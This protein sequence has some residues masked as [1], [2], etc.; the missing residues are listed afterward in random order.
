MVSIPELHISENT[1]V[2]IVGNNGAGKTTL[3]RLIL[4]LLKPNEGNVE[5][6]GI[7]PQVSEEWKLIT[8]AY[9]DAG[10]LIDFLV[11]EEYFDFIAKAAGIAQEE[12]QERIHRF[13]QFMENEILNQKKLIR[14]FSAGNK[15]KVG[16]VGVFINNPKLIIL[17]EPFNFLD[18]SSQNALKRFLVEYKKATQATILISSHN[19]QHTVEIS[20]RVL[21]LEKGCI[22][23]DIEEMNDTNKALLETYFT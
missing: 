3:F 14:D 16:I 8:G 18:P 5:I 19:L 15:Q 2:G 4:D 6:Q 23:H 9:I 17:D 12:A 13:D 22:K 7:D 20:D 21:V 1:I 10:F 11:A